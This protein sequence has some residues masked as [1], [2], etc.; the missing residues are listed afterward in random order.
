MERVN[1]T[2]NVFSIFSLS[3]NVFPQTSHYNIANCDG[4][5]F[6]KMYTL[7]WI[8]T[9]DGI[10]FGHLRQANKCVITSCSALITRNVEKDGSEG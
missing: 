8:E 6:G 5:I 3:E 7:I 4:L 9:E 1:R 10:I 2:V